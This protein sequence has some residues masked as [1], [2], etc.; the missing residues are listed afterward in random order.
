MDENIAGDGFRLAVHDTR[1]GQSLE[2][3]ISRYEGMLL[4]LLFC[5]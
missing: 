4:L 2:R 1:G 5:C 3:E